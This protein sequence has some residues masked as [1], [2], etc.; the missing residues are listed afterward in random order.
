[1]FT[2]FH[3][4]HHYAPRRTDIAWEVLIDPEKKLLLLAWVGLEPP[5]ITLDHVNYQAIVAPNCIMLKP[6]TYNVIQ[7]L[8]C[9]CL[10]LDDISPYT[11]MVSYLDSC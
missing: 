1:M 8:D 4:C 7:Q 2:K 11:Y 5:A 6:A 10:G 9:K 3:E